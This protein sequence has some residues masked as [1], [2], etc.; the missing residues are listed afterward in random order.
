MFYVTQPQAKI[1][2][3]FVAYIAIVCGNSFKSIELLINK[4]ESP[5][6]KILAL[7]TSMGFIVIPSESKH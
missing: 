5:R 2:Q 6:T 1:F 7:S 3:L 4:P